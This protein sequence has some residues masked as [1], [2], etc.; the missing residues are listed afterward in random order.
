MGCFWKSNP[1]NY[2]VIKGA[3]GTWGEIDVP[4]SLLR[5]YKGKGRAII[6]LF[7]EWSVSQWTCG[8]AYSLGCRCLLGQFVQQ[9][10]KANITVLL[11][12][13]VGYDLNSLYSSLDFLAEYQHRG[14]CCC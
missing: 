2:A 8:A 6:L 4:L 10:V 12:S 11:F 5:F 1:V 14:R 9:F 3:F 7:Q 13:Y